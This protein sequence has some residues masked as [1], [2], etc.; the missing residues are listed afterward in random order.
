[1]ADVPCFAAI[2]PTLD[3]PVELEACLRSIAA[4][5]PRPTDVVVADQ[6]SDPG[7]RALVEGLGA[8]Y[9][10]LS[11]RGL[12]RARNAALR[13]ARCPWVWFPD[14][15][16]TA[17]PDLFARVTE[18]LARVPH[19]GFV[20]AR[21]RSPEGRPIMRGMDEV[22]RELRTP[23]DALATVMSPG[24]FVSRRLLAVLRGFD[25]SFGVGAEWGSG[26]ESDLL[27]RAFARGV[28]GLYLPQAHVT[29]PD[30]FAVRDDAAQADRA[31]A[32]GRGWGALFAKHA[33]GPQGTWFAALQ[34]HYEVRALGGAVVSALTLR[35][36]R[37]VHHWR[38]W[39]GRREGWRAWRAAQREPS[40]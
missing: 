3:R 10:H 8:R 17:A 5:D 12:S 22:E 38:T 31:W 23:L 6:G 20:A 39:R 9:V 35:P 28:T 32:Y 26:E 13:T 15:D 34:R 25:E 21:V 29:H 37:A 36:R 4:A 18:G 11:Q 14:D 7:V 40:S 19:A 16:C 30:P 1:M 27:F 24:L 2:V 33:A